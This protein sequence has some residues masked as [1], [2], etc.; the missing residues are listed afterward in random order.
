MTGMNRPI[1]R[2]ALAALV[3]FLIL[4]VDVNYLQAV[5]APSLANKPE[6]GRTAFAQNRVQRGNIV[7]ADGVTIATSKP[8][9]G[10][11]QWQRVLPGRT[12][13]RAG[14]RLRHHLLA[15]AG[16]QLRHRRR[17]RGERPADRLRVAARVPQLH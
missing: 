2:V 15:G 6:N 9:T 13:V 8:S 16:A 4:L 10:L 7:T 11:Y 17:A 12:N 3:M 5:Q 1:K 14:H